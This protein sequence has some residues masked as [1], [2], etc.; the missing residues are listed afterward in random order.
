SPP[1][2]PLPPPCPLP[3]APPLPNPPLL[4]HYLAI[5]FHQSTPLLTLQTHHERIV[6]PRLSGS[7]PLQRGRKP[8]YLHTAKL[9]RVAIRVAHHPNPQT[10]RIRQQ[11]SD[12]RRL[13]QRTDPKLA[14][15]EVLK[16][17]MDAADV[18]GM[19]MQKHDDIQ[20]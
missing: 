11:R 3:T 5:A 13:R 1:A 12:G 4:P 18:I 8:A 10:R 20:M 7:L 14:R 15:T 2:S 17:R 6:L 16:H 9:D 19:R